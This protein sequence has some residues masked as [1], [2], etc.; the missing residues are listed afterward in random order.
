METWWTH[1]TLTVNW[2]GLTV[3]WLKWLVSWLGWLDW[4]WRETGVTGF[5]TGVTGFV[6]GVT[7]LWLDGLEVTGED[8][9]CDWFRLVHRLVRV[10]T[11]S[12]CPETQA[13]VGKWDMA[14]RACVSIFSW[15][16]T[17]STAQKPLGIKSY[18]RCQNFAPKRWVH[19]LP[20]NKADL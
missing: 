11:P 4:D 9:K 12:M 3:K 20:F 7:G 17:K 6:T 16:F 18:F 1:Q 14:T 8:W 13:Y 10:T 2:L 19:T 15:D 5:V